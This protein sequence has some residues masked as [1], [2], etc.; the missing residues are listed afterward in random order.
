M[1]SGTYKEDVMIRIGLIGT[2]ATVS[3]AHFHALGYAAD[4]RAEITAVYDIRADAAEKFCSDHHLNARVCGSLEE[5]IGACDAVDICTPNFLHCSQAEQAMRAGRNVLIEKPVG[6]T[7][8]EC[9]RLYD[10]SL[11]CGGKQMAGMVY[12]WVNAVGLAAKITREELGRIYSVVSWA[13]GRRLA[14][15]RIGLEWRMRRETS[16]FGALADFGSHLIDLADF[17]AGQRFRKVSCMLDTVIG[18]RL[19]AQGEPAAVENDDLSALIAETSSGLHMMHTSRVGM[20]ETMINIT[21]EGGIVQVSLRHPDKVLFWKKECPGAYE[22][23]PREYA[24]EPETWFESWFVK[25]IGTFLDVIEGRA[26]KW[27]DI[28]QGLYIS[29]VI[30]AAG[31]AAAAGTCEE[32]PA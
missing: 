32:V 9:Q 22:K 13:G 30:E 15:E 18:T 16:G 25:E 31:R 24:A 11:E 23:A 8:A 5:L 14:D 28:A 27:P 2:G 10:L 21:G 20:D 4:P 6:V 17:I 1:L 3:I 29:R 12:R 26:E 7:Q 19:N